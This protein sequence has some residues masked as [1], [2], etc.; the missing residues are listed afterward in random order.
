[1]VI[2]LDRSLI[3]DEMLPSLAEQHFG[4]ALPYHLWIVD[5]S[6]SGRSEAPAAVQPLD[7]DPVVFEWG[8][9]ALELGPVEDRPEIRAD[10]EAELFGPLLKNRRRE[11]SRSG[12]AVGMLAAW[13]AWNYGRW[14]LLAQH[15]DGSLDIALDRAR[16]R[17]L[18]VAS[19]ILLVLCAA[20][21]LLTRNAA[22]SRRLARQQLDFVAG[23]THEVMTPLAALRSAGQNLAD[24]VVT[25]PSQVSRYGRMID[26]EGLR[27]GNLV[28]QVLAFARMQS[29]KPQFNRELLDPAAVTRAALDELK[30]Q[31]EA[32]SVEVEHALEDGL[33]Q[34]Q[35]DRQALSR[36]LGNL[37]SNAIKYGQPSPRE[38]SGWIG[39][40]CRRRGT[41]V[42]FEI[43]DKGPGIPSSE[44]ASIFEPFYRGSDKA[45]S[46]IPGTGLGLALVK[47]LVEAQGGK[48]KLT[49]KVGVGSTFTV[50]LPA[51]ADV[52]EA[53]RGNP[54]EEPTP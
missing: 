39:L 1:M 7:R 29:E 19:G 54:S 24:G 27:L 32:E 45:A 25:E 26:R 2:H 22:R 23:I 14:R 5:D 20:L 51:A 18:L 43:E 31:L 35:S 17:N 34:V 21:V 15:P 4:E 6:S 8:P 52:P 40:R 33:P 46:A 44:Q 48:V 12:R 53:L 42:H 47:H 9:G 50:I 30:P 49:S 28:G 3:V 37:L 13:E 10:A 41:E 11:D 16:R 36:A 38:G